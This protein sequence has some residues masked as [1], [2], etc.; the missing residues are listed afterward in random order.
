M[1]KADEKNVKSNIGKHFL[2]WRAFD[3]WSSQ[4]FLTKCE[5]IRFF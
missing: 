1:D 3:Q 4:L 5:Y 2:P